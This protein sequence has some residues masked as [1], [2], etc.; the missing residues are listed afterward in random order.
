MFCMQ[1]G[2][3]VKGTITYI[4]L[5]INLDQAFL[6]DQASAPQAT[7]KQVHKSRADCFRRIANTMFACMIKLTPLA[8]KAARQC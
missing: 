8:T 2:H 7:I 5:L 1:L 6:R 3:W 4:T